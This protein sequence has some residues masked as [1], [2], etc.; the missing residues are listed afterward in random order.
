VTGSGTLDVTTA[1]LYQPGQVLV[2]QAGN[3]SPRNV[4]ADPAGR[5]HLQI[6]LGPSHQFQ[7]YKFDPGTSNRWRHERVTISQQ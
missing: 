6:D 2:V 7:Q 1:A 4:A 3:G 5:L